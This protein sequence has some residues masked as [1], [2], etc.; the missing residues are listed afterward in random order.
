MPA[1]GYQ[2]SFVFT[3]VVTGNHFSG[4]VSLGEYGPAT[5]TATKA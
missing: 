5:F 4:D 1:N 2:I 3:G